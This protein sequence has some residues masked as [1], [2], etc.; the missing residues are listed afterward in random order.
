MF[1][2]N[3]LKA[4][5]GSNHKPIRKGRGIGSGNGKTAGKG[6]KGQNARSGASVGPT[7]EGGQIPLQR[8][9]PKVGF[10]SPLKKYN[11]AINITDLGYYAGK[12]LKLVDLVPKRIGL[13]PRL[14]LSIIGT[15]AP[16]AFPTSLQA[17]RVTPAA[18]AALEAKGVKIEIQTYNDGARPRDKKAVKKAKAAKAAKAK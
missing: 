5:I 10:N 9:S 11:V 13:H 18:K 7:F 12:A 16:K 2:L 17:H 14:R 1:K 15:K 6:H 8:R 4:P 3:N